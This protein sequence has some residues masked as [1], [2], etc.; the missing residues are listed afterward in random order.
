ME[1]EINSIKFEE[2]SN[3]LLEN[4]KKNNILEELNKNIIEEVKKIYLNFI[5]FSIFQFFLESETK[6]RIRLPL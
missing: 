5:Q 3:K 6:A 1:K 2:I 4:Q